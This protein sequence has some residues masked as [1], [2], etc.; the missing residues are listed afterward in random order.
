MRYFFAH[1]DEKQKLLDIFR[2]FRKKI[3]KNALF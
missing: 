3:A 2:N 1:L